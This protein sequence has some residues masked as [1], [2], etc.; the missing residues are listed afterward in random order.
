MWMLADGRP[1]YS[2]SIERIE[3]DAADGLFPHGQVTIRGLGAETRKEAEENNQA[4]SD[5]QDDSPNDKLTI[6]D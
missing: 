3:T 4:N 2:L 5:L 1:A 6:D